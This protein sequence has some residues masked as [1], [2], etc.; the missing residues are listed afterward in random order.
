M[1]CD[2]M[3]FPG[4]VAIVCSRGRRESCQ[5]PGCHNSSTKLCDYP[6]KKR[7]RGVVIDHATCDRKMCDSCAT[8]QPAQPGDKDSRDYCRTHHEMANPRPAEPEPAPRITATVG[9]VCDRC[10]KVFLKAARVA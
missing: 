2:R 9:R 4:G 8:R 1:K 3:D 7:V 5:T 6:V 10:R